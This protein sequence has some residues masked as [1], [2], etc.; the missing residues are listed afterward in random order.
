MSRAAPR[1]MGRMI[2]SLVSIVA[3]VVVVPAALIAASRSMFG[4]GR[5]W[6]GVDPPWTWETSK[7]TAALGDR[8]ADD[9]LID[10][11]VRLALTTVWAALIVVVA[12]TLAETVQM[13]RHGGLSVPAV[14]GLGWAQRVGHFIASGLIMASPTVTP[15]AAMATSQVPAPQV[16]AAAAPLPAI[17]IDP[18][19]R[20]AS[21][22]FPDDSS[23]LDAGSSSERAPDRPMHV[24]TRGESVYS[25]AAGLAG[26]DPGRT[27][28]IAMAIIDLN[29]GAEMAT[30]RF[31]NP[32][33]IEPGWTLE[34]PDVG[35][36]V[37]T[38][39]VHAGTRTHTVAAGDTL[40]SIAAEHLGDPAAWSD[41][42]NEN[43]GATMP[44]GRTFDDPNLI[45]PGWELDVPDADHPASPPEAADAVG[46][47]QVDER[48]AEPSIDRPST[49]GSVVTDGEPDD[50]PPAS[51]AGPGTD[52]D[53]AGDRAP[54]PRAN[55]AGESVEVISS[56]APRPPITA[57]PGP[58]S[59]PIARS[60]D[61][62]VTPSTADDADRRAAP[63]A[64]DDS[65]EADNTVSTTTDVPGAGT[66]D[67]ATGSVA[68]DQPSA[69][70]PVRLEH[71][72]V[73]A[74]GILALV[75]V[76]RRARLRGARP[77]SRVPDPHPDVSATERRLRIIDPGERALR[78][79]VATRAAAAHILEEAQIGLVEISPDGE[80]T[81]VL[82]APA[83]LP[84][85]WE[86]GG[87]R[88]SL[89]ATV[90]VELLGA[91]ARQVGAPCLALVQL[92]TT[93]RGNDL[94]IDLEA[95]G[96]LAIDAR[97]EQADEIVTALAA[98]LASSIHAEVA[99]LIGVSCPPEAF[100]GHRNTH[101]ADD[102]DAA[103][104]L[105]ASLIGST[106]SSE[107]SSFEMRSLR[108][109]GEMWEPAIVLLTSED[110][111]DG[112]ALRPIPPGQGC[113][114][115]AATGAEGLPSAPARLRGRPEG[116]SLDAFGAAVRIRPVG[117][118]P[119]ELDEVAAMLDDARR[120][121][122][123]R[124]S[125]S[126]GACN[127]AVEEAVAHDGEGRHF[128]GREH[129]VVVHLLDGVAIRSADGDDGRFE[130]SKTVEL[131][132]WLATHRGRMTRSAARTALWE[133]DVR[134]ATFANVVSEARRGLARLVD[135]PEGEEWLARTL[136]DEL[137]LHDL[138][139][140]DADLI[141]E[142]LAAARLQPPTEAIDTLRPA[143]ELVEGMPFAGT[144]YL[145]PDADGITS[146]ILLTATGAATEL[147]AHAL[148]VGDTELVFWATGRALQVLPGHEELIGLRMRA[149]AHAGDLAAVRQEWESYERVI[150]ADAWS[151]GEPAPKLLELRHELLS[152][153]S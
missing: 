31:T 66:G 28:D 132:A 75:G 65:L 1:H 9:T 81:L 106:L 26:G 130:R 149:H 19:E 126:A 115:V 18:P 124:P 122:V 13:R 59:S 103:L 34:L 16:E 24:V 21:P 69:P 29:L 153:G 141:E 138:V 100:L 89:P 32:A 44:A 55:G 80:V 76:G 57:A 83:S 133:L 17:T 58:T 49:D 104:D 14:R 25:I 139:V 3:L 43:A 120:P 61:T 10:V 119:A 105:A 111:A 140:T 48:A 121:L 95:C 52:T 114:V 93:E 85:P 131:I 150:V 92:G 5:P 117:L 71:A 128:A 20:P 36:Q 137:P 82:T 109:G 51:N 125:L 97:P 146:N 129:R 60:A 15:L 4:S 108:T 91:S 152:P 148:A 68:D 42:W 123:D 112:A 37:P 54:E 144:S 7:I 107:R 56:P 134:D 86:G 47:A 79:D 50:A 46:D 98:G 74:A 53:G 145:W 135:P 22:A 12:T 33:Y 23:R 73:L 67:D 41:I 94:L 40:T 72:A 136:T 30:G 142:R 77:R 116:W 113:A 8:L 45:L 88:W 6:H 84:G 127:V 11:I 110:D 143:V 38:P 147:A 39:T 27:E 70:S 118:D 78:A 96:T 35:V 151:D 101:R 87:T 63:V 99:H 2:V 64:L 90:P 62:P 102:V